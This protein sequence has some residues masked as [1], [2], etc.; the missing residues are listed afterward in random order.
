LT[1]P[2][3]RSVR[4]PEGVVHRAFGEQLVLLNLRTGQ[5]HG[6]NQSARRMFEVMVERGQVEGV[7]PLV[8]EEFEGAEPEAVQADL[9]ELC[10]DLVERGLL[11]FGS[12]DS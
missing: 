11:E 1:A 9:N 5:Y 4:V 6:L 7:A 10:R 12:G 3:S 2:G 8:A